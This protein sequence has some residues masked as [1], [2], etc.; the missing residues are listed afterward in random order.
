MRPHIQK[1]VD[2]LLD[3]MLSGG[4]EKPF[5]IVDKFALPVPSSVSPLFFN[6]SLSLLHLLTKTSFFFD[7]RSYMAFLEFHSRTSSISLSVTQSEVTEVRQQPKLPMPISE[8][9][10]FILYVICME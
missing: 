6:Q 4:G 3:K 5:D 10:V 7:E 9:G 8:F 1:T 2:S